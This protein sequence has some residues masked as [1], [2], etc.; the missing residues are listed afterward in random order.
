MISSFRITRASLVLLLALSPIAICAQTVAADD[1]RAKL[2]EQSSVYRGWDYLVERL[3]KDGMNYQLIQ[4]VYSNKRMPRFTNVTYKLKPRE[5]KNIYRHFT[6]PKKLQRAVKYLD[7]YESTFSHTE[8][9]FGVAPP[10]VSS[11]LLIETH[12]GA[13]TGKELII[14]RLSRLA[15][16]SDPDN[17]QHNYQK[18]KREGQAVTY[19]QVAERGVY[20]HEMFYP[21]VVAAFQIAEQQGVDLFSMKGSYAG[22]FGLPQFLPT[23]YLK[24]GTDGNSDGKI[25]LF[26]DEDAI[27]SIGS[28]LAGHGWKD[29]LPLP[30]KKKVIW[31]YNHSDAY[32]DTVLEVA[33]LIEQKI[34]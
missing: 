6:A 20:L 10:V 3:K 1:A 11:I 31:H 8:K 9:R 33:D 27:A 7:K 22:A 12:F 32:V 2:A 4:R 23:T 21:E 25:S 19:E 17:M 14:N 28:F 34:R 18:L 13:N 30:E 16:I 5:S 26:D 24:Y 29:T 15:S